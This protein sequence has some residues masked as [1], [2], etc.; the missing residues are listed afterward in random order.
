MRKGTRPV[1]DFF[2]YAVLVGM[3]GAPVAR[4]VTTNCAT[5][6]TGQQLCVSIDAPADGATVFVPPGEVTVQGRVTIGAFTGANINVMYVVDVSGSLENSGFNP[7]QDL[8]GDGLINTADDC[9]NDGINGSAMDATCFGLLALNGS[10]GNLPT[11]S[12]G[13]VAFASGAKTADMGPAV[14]AQTF[15]APPQVDANTNSTPDVEEVIRSLDTTYLG[16]SAAGVGLFT[17]DITNGFATQTDYDAAL[18]AMNTAFAARP[19]GQR[20]IAFFLSDGQPTT[21][22]TGAGSP[23]STAVAA[24][25]TVNTFVLGVVAPGECAPGK[26][27]RSIADSTGGTCTEVADPS[28]LSAVL[29]G[30]APA[31]IDHVTVNG[32]TVPLDPLGQW[33]RALTGIVLGPNT[34]TA[35]AFASDATSVAASITV[36]GAVAPSATPTATATRTPTSTPTN[37]PTATPTSTP[38]NTSPPPPTDIPTAT[39]TLTPTPTPTSTATQTPTHTPTATPT[40]SFTPVPTNTP[41]ATASPTSTPTTTPTRTPTATPTRTATATGTATPTET[42]TA[43]PTATPTRTATATAT[44]TPPNTSTAT[45]TAT[46][47]ATPSSTPTSSPSRTPSASPSA[48]PTSSPTR[49]ATSTP[50][51]TPT[52]TPVPPPQLRVE[53]SGP[54]DF[55]S[56]LVGRSRTFTYSARNT[57]GAVLTGTAGASCPGFSVAPAVLSLAA[58]EQVAL[59]VT[60]APPGVGSFS[61][62]LSIQT[63]GGA[64]QIG[65]SG[66]GAAPPPIP[67]VSAPNSPAGIVMI[68]LLALAITRLLR[69]RIGSSRSP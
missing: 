41:T 30:T 20:N 24:G 2:L 4:A 27:L 25:T 67:V 51:A 42:P 29:P 62:E 63:N 35:T 17:A 56:V 57:G 39:P 6:T 15:T 45:P 50:T 19:A 60:F 47:T 31:G 9:N 59:V 12:A 16:T 66:A 28:L 54:Y 34:I 52:N 69:A 49:T 38:T 64:A 1:L 13:L 68:G 23:L 58:N 10:L 14:G 26:P 11:V 44:A 46:A 33:S 53:P 32:V 3:L 40:N 48:P 5:T 21:F 55:R 22:T 65:L 61:C 7:F 36:N 43:T 8:T 18:S 37:T